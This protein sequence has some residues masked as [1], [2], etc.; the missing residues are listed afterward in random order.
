MKR[1]LVALVAATAAAAPLLSIPLEACGDKFM[2]PGRGLGFA[3]A[4]R[5]RYPGTVMIYSP[6]GSGATDYSKVVSMLTRAGHRVMVVSDARQV[7]QTVDAIHA[8]VVLAPLDEATL[9]SA[10]A[11][12]T[13]AAPVILPVLPTGTKAEKAACKQQPF[14]CDLRAKDG[15]E[16]F[17]VTVNTT[18][19]Q[20]AKS[21]P[22]KTPAAR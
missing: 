18:I 15:P 13:A 17:T 21:R 12:A 2:M 16:K 10:R 19:A 4:Y 22:S 1:Q 5:A 9:I 20:R 3:D 14:V 7:T 8:D 11:R 6:G